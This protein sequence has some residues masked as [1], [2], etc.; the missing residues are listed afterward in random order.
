MFGLQINSRPTAFYPKLNREHVKIFLVDTLYVNTGR[1]GQLGDLQNYW[2]VAI[3]FEL[4][5]L[6]GDYAGAVKAARCMHK[7]SPPS[8]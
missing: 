5:V 1:K 3:F 7:L 6:S 4:S 2:D 8:W